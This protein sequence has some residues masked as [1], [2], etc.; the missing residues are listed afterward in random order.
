MENRGKGLRLGLVFKEIDP[1]C[2]QVYG[3]Q[4]YDEEKD[5]LFPDQFGSNV[6]AL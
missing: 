5:D 3:D 1:G 6:K 2:G 4:A